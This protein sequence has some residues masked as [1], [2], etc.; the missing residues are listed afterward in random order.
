MDPAKA[1]TLQEVLASLDVEH[2]GMTFTS[3]PESPFMSYVQLSQRAAASGGALADAGLAPGDRV[4]LVLPDERD[5]LESFFGAIWTGAIP[6]PLFP[7]FMLAQLATYVE[8]IRRI[9]KQC[10][11]SA[12]VTIAEVAELLNDTDGIPRCV[13]W[14]QPEPDHPLPPPY[15]ADP[16]DIAFIQYTSGSTS[17][18]KG[19]VSTHRCLLDNVLAFARHMRLHPDRDRGVSWLPLYHDMGLIGGAMLPLLLQGSISY[20]TP[21]EFARHPTTWF[22][23]LHE[24]HGT[25]TFAPNF[26]YSLISRRAGEEQ[27]ETWDLSRL[28]IAGCA[29]EPIRPEVLREFERR[30]AAAGLSPTALLPCYGLAEATLAVTMSEISGRWRSLAVSER[31]FTRSGIAKPVASEDKDALE[32]VSCGRPLPS[33]RVRIGGADGDPAAPGCQGEIEVRTPA[34]TTGYFESPEATRAALR[35]GWLRTGDLGL[36][37]EGELFVTGRSTDMLIVNGRNVHPQDVEWRAAEIEGV[38]AGSVVACGSSGQLGEEVVLVL[39]R[40]GAVAIPDLT[41]RVAAHVAT[42]CRVPVADVI[43][44]ARGSIPKTTSGKLKRNDTRAK[45]E[46]GELTVLAQT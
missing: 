16:D 35:D 23:L 21:L 3:K 20:M 13:T 29:A 4:L 28:R 45:Y 8:H 31:E 12:L 9:A 26:A 19:V 36:L 33:Y 15:S 17:K 37:H 22:D 42:E 25:I 32:L 44:V 46:R 7:P 39:E 30:F 27:L 41:R 24:T 10:E 6:V 5:F 11:A 38:R 1:A 40:A 43:V 2:E 14:S 18:P 34:L